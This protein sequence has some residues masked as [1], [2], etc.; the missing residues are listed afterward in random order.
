MGDENENQK[1]EPG[2]VHMSQGLL[3]TTAIAA[4]TYS[5]SG[6]YVSIVRNPVAELD[7][8]ADE[9]KSHVQ[10]YDDRIDDLKS[11]IDRNSYRI[12]DCMDKV[13]R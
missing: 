7:D 2:R 8:L 6:L 10:I 5:L 3:Y 12:E 4:L 9:F 11:K 13:N 1:R